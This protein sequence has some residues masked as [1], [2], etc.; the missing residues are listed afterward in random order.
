MIAMTPRTFVSTALLI[1]WI[2]LVPQAQAAGG[3]IAIKA[4]RIVTLAGP[5]I[6]NGIITIEDGR[7][8]GVSADAQ[9][10]WDADV[11]DHP[12][13]VAFPGFVEAHS[14]RGMDRPNENVPVAPFLD[15]RD[16][17]DPISFYFE[18]SLRAGVLTINIQQGNACVVGG[19]GMIVKPYGITIEQM[20]V[21]TQ[22]GVKI[23]AGPRPGASRATQAQALRRAFGDLRR[24]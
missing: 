20:A 19:Q 9:A 7:I 17:I 4:G 8:T 15:V 21:R 16:S 11:L 22:S 5:D 12:E 6:V 14:N 1:G 13:L 2:A 24:Y 23:S 10:P 3:K 18:D